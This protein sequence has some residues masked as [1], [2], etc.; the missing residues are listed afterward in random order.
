MSYCLC[1]KLLVE[2]GP[3]SVIRKSTSWTEL[4][5]RTSAILYGIAIIATPAYAEPATLTGIVTHVRDGDTVE[6][7][8]IPIRQ[9]A[10]SAPERY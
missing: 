10:V 8:K 5:Q 1:G 6:I 2:G 9:Y 4:F 3:D 7:G